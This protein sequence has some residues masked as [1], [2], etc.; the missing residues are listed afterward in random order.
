MMREIP[1]SWA[2]VELD[3]T[4]RMLAERAARLAGMPVEQW[5]ERAIRRTC[6]QAFRPAAPAPIPVQAPPPRALDQSLAD[7]IAAAR[8]P[9]RPTE[10][11]PMAPPRPA[12]MPP[13]TAYQPEPAPRPIRPMAPLPTPDNI[14]FGAPAQEPRLADPSVAAPMPR[15]RRDASE[16]V[17]EA[18]APQANEPHPGEPEASPARRQAATFAGEMTDWRQREERPA[19]FG[20]PWPTF[21][22]RLEPTDERGSGY[23]EPLELTHPI[24][25][26]RSK[27]P[28]FIAVAIALAVTLGAL[29]AQRMMTA[30]GRRDTAYMPTV[31]TAPSPARPQQQAALTPAPQQAQEPLLP[32]SLVS[33]NVPTQPTTQPIVTPQPV[34]QAATVAPSMPVVTPPTMPPQPAMVPAPTQSPPVVASAPPQPLTPMANTVPTMDTAVAAAPEPPPLPARKVAVA[35]SP[36]TPA[37]P[38]APPNAVA[39]KKPAGDVPQDPAKLAG[40]LEERV[41]SGDP[42]AEYRLGVLYALGQGVKQDYAHSAQLFKSAADGGVAEAQYNVAVMYSEGMGVQRDPAQA[43]Q[44]YQKAAAQGNGNAA[45]NLGVAY[46]NGNGV[47]QNIE[48]ASR[49]F[50]RAA[51][52]GVVNAQYNLGLLYERGEGVPASSIE[53]YAWFAAAAARGDQGAAQRRDHL[54]ATFSPADLKQAEGRAAQ[55]QKTIQ[56]GNAAPGDQKTNAAAR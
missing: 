18:V 37:T 19:R 23:D 12:M 27:R 28:L 25:A 15:R 40:W 21:D 39:A 46:S 43:V 53:A 56:T 42:V 55:L 8:Q 2:T 13:P 31:P 32:P 30:L 50:R 38:V 7:L 3:A 51:A 9:H 24:R 26:K 10:P 6:P 11:K 54:A 33:P 22:D 52:A 48:E 35:K 29:G 17:D 47:S 1:D 45:F 16:W 36:V 20:A 41:K 34:P 14:P 5:L 4:I 49:W 44:W